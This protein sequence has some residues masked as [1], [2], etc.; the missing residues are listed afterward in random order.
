MPAL[1]TAAAAAR[2]LSN[3]PVRGAVS[4][5]FFGRSRS[6]CAGTNVNATAAEPRDRRPDRLVEVGRGNG[7]RPDRARVGLRR[8][9]VPNAV[10]LRHRVG[11]EPPHDLDELIGEIE[12]VVDAVM[13]HARI[14][15]AKHDPRLQKR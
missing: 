3:E 12:E 1:L 9:R 14:G 4:N 11:R 7:E 8:L 5:G 6:A 10:A 15:D 2:G 13:E